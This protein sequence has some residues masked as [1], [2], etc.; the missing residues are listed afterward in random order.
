M[1]REQFSLT[2]NRMLVYFTPNTI[3]ES[4]CLLVAIFCLSKDRSNYWRIFILYLLLTCLTEFAGIF[5]RRELHRPN[6]AVY[7]IHKAIEGGVISYFFFYLLHPYRNVARWLQIW[8][9]LFAVAYTAE[10]WANHFGAFV[11]KT[12]TAMSVVFVIA[13][14]Y[15]YYLMLR[16]DQFRSLWSDAPFWWVSGTLFFYFGSTA[17][18]LF[19]EYLAEDKTQLFR[20]SVRHIIFIILDIVLYTSWSYSFICRYR[21]RILSSLSR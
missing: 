21:Q 9:V 11:F 19:F 8:L 14:L 18:N 7:N 13:C 5:I 3:S 10:L 1:R 15:Y 16:D 2:T 17:C 12:T 20:N 4:L 6:F